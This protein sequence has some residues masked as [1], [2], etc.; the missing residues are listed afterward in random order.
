[1]IPAMRRTSIILLLVAAAC[2][3][4]W[5]ADATGTEEIT[6]PAR[7]EQLTY[8][9]FEFEVP[10][11][12]GYRHTLDN[13]VVVYAAEDRALPLINL[14]ITVRAGAF[15]DPDDKPGVA[16][17][18]GR[19]LRRG[20][21]ASMTASEFDER[22]DFLAAQLS[23]FGGDTSSGASANCLSYKLEECLDLFFEMLEAP[24]FEAGRMDVEKTNIIEGM[25]QRN[26]D[27]STIS[28]R[29][30]GWLM[31]GMEHFSAR[32][33]T[34]SEV[35]AITREDLSAFH[36]KYWEPKN[37]IISVSGDFDV[38][39]MLAELGRRFEGWKSEGPK[40]PWPPKA[41]DHEPTPGL[42]HVEKDIPQSRVLI[43]HLTKESDWTDPDRLPMQVMNDVLGGGGFTSRIT[44]RVRSD[45]GLAYSA[46]SA[47]S[48]GRYWPGTFMMYFQTKNSTVPLAAKIAL[49]EM[50]RIK[51]EKVSDEEL[52]V[53]KASFIDTFP[54]NFDSADAIVGIFAADEFNDRPHEYWYDYQDR[55]RAVT[56]EDVQ[57][58]AK[59]YLQPE[60]LTYLIVGRWEEVAAGDTEKRAN[61][62]EF[63]EGKVTHLPLRDPLTLEPIE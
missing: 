50:R 5:A 17:M 47:M 40:V 61:I 22:A 13:G 46:G 9:P 27:A 37:M 53:S 16:S 36:E 43:G 20:G 35:Q 23:S 7:P 26:D 44:N 52:S 38:D 56:A 18:T 4:A 15:L 28:S 24:G 19:M 25:K 51:S 62:E 57:R 34:S 49:E 33:L 14:S 39:A 8:E 3:L 11:A 29:E 12:D 58:V 42:Y 10:R 59:A 54:Q 1:M 55:V 60:Q 41:P 6:I 63:H 45:E 31:R 2:G 32:Q 48:F 30:W 21:T